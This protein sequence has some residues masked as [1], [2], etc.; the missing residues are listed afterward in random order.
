MR[1]SL[2]LLV[3]RWIGYLQRDQTQKER[4]SELS[5][6]LEPPSPN[7]FSHA[8][9]KI[10]YVDRILRATLLA[11]PFTWYGARR[12]AYLALLTGLRCPGG[13]FISTFAG[14]MHS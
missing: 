7:H 6:C 5:E 13:Y 10:L 9:Q 11:M 12:M 4:N 3:H 14:I 2:L 8:Y 1:S